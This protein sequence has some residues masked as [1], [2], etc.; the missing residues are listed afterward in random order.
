MAHQVD[1]ATMEGASAAVA[2]GQDA[3]AAHGED[4]GSGAV[5]TPTNVAHLGPHAPFHGRTI[6]WV[7]V[8]I[9]VVGFIVGGLA[10]IVGHGGSVWWLFWTGVGISVLGLLVMMATNT[11]EDWY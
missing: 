1:P 11:F 2:A 4:A 10:L 7:A 5:A 8:S 6:S 9:I 3:S